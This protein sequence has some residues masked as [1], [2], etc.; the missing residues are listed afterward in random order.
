[1]GVNINETE[2]DKIDL[3]KDLELARANLSEKLND[4]G[5]EQYNDPL[6]HLPLEEMKYIE[7]KSDSSDEEE[8]R[9][10]VS[11]KS[12][13]KERRKQKQIARASKGKIAQPLDGHP[14]LM[15]VYLE[16]ALNITLEK[17]LLGPKFA[18]DRCYLEL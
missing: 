15:E 9:V 8:F 6:N 4:E 3:L 1:M 2:M 7:W 13:K 11:R 12:K 17:G 18:N 5:A 16:L 10:V 14:H